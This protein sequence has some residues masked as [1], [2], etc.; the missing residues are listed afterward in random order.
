MPR[1]KTIRAF[2]IELDFFNTLYLVAKRYYG[3]HKSLFKT[4]IL[5]NL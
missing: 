2:P 5:N 4:L 1:R 3:T